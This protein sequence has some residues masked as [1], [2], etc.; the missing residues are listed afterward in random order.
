M[1][2]R[3][4]RDLGNENIKL[5]E[6]LDRIANPI[7]AMQRQVPEDHCF[8]G[9]AALALV[10]KEYLQGIASAALKSTAPPPP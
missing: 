8:D 2:Y 6:A 9:A 10:T 1:L 7:S 5:R 4:I 3:R